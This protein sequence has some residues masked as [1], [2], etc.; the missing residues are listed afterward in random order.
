MQLFP[1]AVRRDKDDQLLPGFWPHLKRH[2][3]RS[4]GSAGGSSS[5]DVAVHYACLLDAG[6][7]KAAAAGGGNPKIGATFENA[8][9]TPLGNLH[10]TSDDMTTTERG[11]LSVARFCYVFPCELRGPARAVGS[12]SISQSAGGTSKNI[13]FKT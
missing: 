12:Y 4:A 6:K 9:S 5:A 13:I 1:L 7:A 2:L 11:V 3:R 10:C 8:L